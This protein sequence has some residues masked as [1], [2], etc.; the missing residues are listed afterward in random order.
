ME[1]KDNLQLVF[2]EE[3]LEVAHSMSKVMRFTPN[4]RHHKDSPTNLEQLQI[5]WADLLAMK[6]LIEEELGIKFVT[7]RTPDLIARKKIRF[8]EYEHYSKLLG[9]IK[10]AG[11]D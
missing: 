8:R 7:E 3:C 6:E 9:T 2:M 1:S 11:A 5:E 4:D 10:D